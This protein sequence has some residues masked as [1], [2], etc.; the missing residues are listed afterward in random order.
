MLSEV[1]SFPHLPLSKH[2]PTRSS[3][4]KSFDI[5]YNSITIHAVCMNKQLQVPRQVPPIKNISHLWH[6]PTQNLESCRVGIVWK[7]LSRMG[8]IWVGNVLGK[9]SRGSSMG[10]K[11]PVGFVLEPTPSINWVPALIDNKGSLAFPPL[12][13][14][15]M[16]NTRW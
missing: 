7:K 8:I 12:N 16:K 2:V 10:G 9:L 13:N 3:N 11:F 14:Q 6:S 5:R 1:L 4:V 15:V